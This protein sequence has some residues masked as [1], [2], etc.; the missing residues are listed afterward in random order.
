MDRKDE[1]VGWKSGEF[2]K[3]IP[4]RSAEHDPQI[5]SRDK[6]K[7]K[8]MD[9]GGGRDVMVIWVQTP[10]SRT[11]LANHSPQSVP[12]SPAGGDYLHNLAPL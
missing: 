9:G 10:L 1:E 6:A 3:L 12:P 5:G 11:Q 8:P 2:A 7:S 4:D